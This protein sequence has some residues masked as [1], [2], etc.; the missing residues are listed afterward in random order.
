MEWTRTNKA[1]KTNYRIKQDSARIRPPLMVDP[2]YIDQEFRFF[3]S[4]RSRGCSSSFGGNGGLS[5]I[6]SVIIPWRCLSSFNGSGRSSNI[7]SS[8]TSRGFPSSF[9]TNVALS[10]SFSWIHWFISL[11]PRLP[12]FPS[13]GALKRY[14]STL[15]VENL[16]SHMSRY[17][18]QINKSNE[19][20]TEY[21]LHQLLQHRIPVLA[22]NN[23]FILDSLVGP[24]I[25]SKQNALLARVNTLWD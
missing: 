23:P 5:D 22:V 14:I 8:A 18:Y 20:R 1:A 4:V 2:C 9:D 7:L 15:Y 10:N 12:P 25:V 13:G 16:I 24:R 6:F 21:C 19:G 3:S 11:S 17:E